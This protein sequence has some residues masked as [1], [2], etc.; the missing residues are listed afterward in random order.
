MAR[1]RRRTVWY[2]VI[3]NDDTELP[4]LVGTLKECS[5]YV[6]ISEVSIKSQISNHKN[7]IDKWTGRYKFESVRI[8][9]ENV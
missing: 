9:Y 2:M 1:E 8:G 5:D 7:K 6:G 3:E 4:V